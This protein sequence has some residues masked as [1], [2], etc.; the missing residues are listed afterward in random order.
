MDIH[1][2]NPHSHSSSPIYEEPPCIC[3]K[4]TNDEEL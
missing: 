3:N 1:E 4:Y 2:I